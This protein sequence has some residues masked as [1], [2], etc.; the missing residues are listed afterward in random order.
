M[1]SSIADWLNEPVTRRT[2]RGLLRFVGIAAAIVVAV[3][4][5]FVGAGYMEAKRHYDA[6][7]QALQ[8]MDALQQR[9]K[10]IAMEA[11]ANLLQDPSSATFDNVR[12]IMDRAYKVQAVCGE[13]YG[14]NGFGVRRRTRFVLASETV[15]L[16]DGGSPSG[17]GLSLWSEHC[18]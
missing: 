13:M 17:T 4:L 15:Y 9:L 10:N 12:V 5:Y 14:T 16:L 18:T 8:N 11:A 1:T 6:R 3:P 7:D 2:K